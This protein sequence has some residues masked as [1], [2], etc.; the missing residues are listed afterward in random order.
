M[1]EKNTTDQT[2]PTITVPD[3]FN[4]KPLGKDMVF[5]PTT[6]PDCGET[7]PLPGAHQ[8]SPGYTDLQ[9]DLTTAHA[10]IA[11]QRWRKVEEEKPEYC[12]DT[13]YSQNILILDDKQVVIGNYMEGKFEW[14]SGSFRNINEPGSQ[15]SITHW[16]PIP[17]LPKE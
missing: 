15:K 4:L 8:C 9:S 17:P 16:M 2:N 10:T 3:G 1:S 7:T 12:P 14:W 11:E 5:G 13:K 6:C